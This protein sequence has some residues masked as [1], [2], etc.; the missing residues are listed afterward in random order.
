MDWLEVDNLGKSYAGRP[1]VAGATFSIAAGETVAFLG[2]NGAGKSTTLRMI[3]G[4][5][6]PDQGDARVQGQSI[7]AHRIAAQSRFG[8]LPESAPVYADLSAQDYL[9]FLARLHGLGAAAR[10]TAI[11][12]VAHDARIEDVLPQPVAALSKGYRRRVALAGAMIHDPPVLLLDEPTDGLDPN[13]K[14]VMRD[15]LLRMRADKAILISTHQLDEVEA[16][17]TRALVIAKGRILANESPTDLAR[18]TPSG[19]LEDAFA[20]LTREE[21]VLGAPPPPSVSLVRATS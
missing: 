8:Y 19:R 20:A 16:M 3:A 7:T 18:R 12:R 2:P 10:R 6:D 11:A 5:L 4:C 15:W 13:Q 17:C 14:A 21:V 1:V 9:G